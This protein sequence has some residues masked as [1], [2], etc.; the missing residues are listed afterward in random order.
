MAQPKELRK[1]W[2][3]RETQAIAREGIEAAQHGDMR[4]TRRL[5]ITLVRRHMEYMIPYGIR[6]IRA[7]ATIDN[8]RGQG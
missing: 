5:S 6:W 4:M 7:Q 1:P 2:P 3:A 8:L